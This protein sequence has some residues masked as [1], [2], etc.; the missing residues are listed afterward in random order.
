MQ[1]L[2]TPLPCADTLRQS[3]TAMQFGAPDQLRPGDVVAR[4][5]RGQGCLHA[6]IA[7]SPGIAELNTIDARLIDVGRRP[8]GDQIANAI[9]EI[10]GIKLLR[11]RRETQSSLQVARTFRSQ[12]GIASAEA[13]IR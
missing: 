13:G 6:G 4:V 7:E 12:G 2:T 1:P 11:I 9:V 10:H 5:L 3:E 8:A